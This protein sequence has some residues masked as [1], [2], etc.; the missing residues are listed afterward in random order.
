[1]SPDLIACANTLTHF[2]GFLNGGTVSCP[3]IAH[4]SPAPPSYQRQR[5]GL[6]VALPG[7]AALTLSRIFR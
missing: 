4:D 6:P 1:M 2:A 5:G 7:R 3:A